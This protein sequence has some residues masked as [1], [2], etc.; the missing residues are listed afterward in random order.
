MALLALPG[1]AAPVLAQTAEAPWYARFVDEKDGKFDLSEHLLKHRGFLPVP[2]IVTEPAVGYGGGLAALWFKESVEDA[3]QRALS[4][5]Q[6]PAPPAIGALAGFRT[7]NGSSGAFGG[8]F[9]PLDGDRYRVL[10]GAGTVG[11]NLDYYDRTGRPAAYRLDGTGLLAQALMRMGKSDW[12]VGVRY[13][14]VGTQSQFERER[15]RDI[16]ARDLEARIGRL[17]LIVDYDS[18]DN[19]F[20][21]NRGTYME[22]EFAY[23]G[24]S[25]GGNTEF[26]SLATRAFHYVPLGPV[27]LG[28]RGDYRATSAGTPFFARPYVVL[29]GIPAL[30][31]QDERTAVG[32]VE[33]RWNIT[34]RW[35]LVGFAGAGKAYG[36]RSTWS[37]AETVTTRGAGFRYL[38]AR[39]LGLY[40]GLDV[41]RGPEEQAIYIQVGGAWM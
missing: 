29:R 33:A 36:G 17:S 34:P 26:R 16:P 38:L 28:L 22:T 7:E 3:S 2:I 30:R 11:L 23:A 6:R 19:L 35:A 40:A 41:A 1:L 37:D 13:A 10:A 4:A 20:T 14:Y 8:Y 24:E 32:E 9:A 5:G 39:R 15:V 25:L 12:L 27:V 21:P 18:R 31:Y